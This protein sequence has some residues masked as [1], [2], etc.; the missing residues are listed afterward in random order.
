MIISVEGNKDKN[1]NKDFVDN[2][3]LAQTIPEH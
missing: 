2:Y 3:L 1:T